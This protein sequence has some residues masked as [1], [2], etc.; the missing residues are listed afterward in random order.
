MRNLKSV[1]LA[2]F[3]LPYV[4]LA[5]AGS[6]APRRSIFDHIAALENPSI[7]LESN[8]DSIVESRNDE[9]YEPATLTLSA[10]G[11]PPEVW[12]VEIRNRARYRRRICDFP[13]IKVKFPKQAL[14]DQGFADHN[15]LKL[16]THCLKSPE[17][18]ENLREEYFIYKLYEQFTPA[19]H[20]AKLVSITYI[21]TANGKELQRQAIFLEDEKELAERL[22]GELSEDSFGLPD[23]A[24]QEENLKFLSLFQYFIGNSDWSIVMLRNLKLIK[25]ND[26]SRFLLVPYD[27]DFSGVVNARYAQP[28][29]TLPISSVRHRIMLGP[30][31]YAE[32]L[33]AAIQRLERDR[34]AIF[35]FIET[36]EP[37]EKSE[38][39]WINRYLQSYYRDIRKFPRQG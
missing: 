8:L 11:H 10:E 18:G 33:E 32:E 26:G 37:L 20:R 34:E 22:G 36:F 25:P 30:F 24:F 14:L 15:E 7:V 27:F 3:F 21:N 1:F 13:P 39:R 4:A 5:Q 9:R 38:R 31:S 19:H 28:D 29:G 35:H 2:A 23:S 12:Q 6:E 16:V 17:G